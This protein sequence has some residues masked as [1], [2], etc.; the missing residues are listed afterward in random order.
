M[1]EIPSFDELISLF[2]SCSCDLRRSLLTLQFLA[3]SSSVPIVSTNQNS[4]IT[5]PQWQSSRIFDAV[6][7]SHLREQ[8]DESILKTLF[9]DLTLKYNSDYEQSHL[10]LLNRSKNDSKR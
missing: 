6:Y 10:L 3:Q 9:D 5:K 4:I 7:Y 2:Q 8:W 1:L